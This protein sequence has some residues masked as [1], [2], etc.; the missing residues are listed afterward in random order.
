MAYNSTFDKLNPDVGAIFK[1]T[2]QAVQDNVTEMI[3]AYTTDAQ[4]LHHPKG[5]FNAIF[6]DFLNNQSVLK[7][8]VDTLDQNKLDRGGYVGTAQNLKSEVDDKLPKGTYAGDAGQLKTAID[9]KLAAGTY[10]GNAGQLKG[11]IDLKQNKNDS[12]LH[13]TSKTV[14]GS[15]NETLGIAQS[16]SANKQNKNDSALGTSNKTVVGAI[17]ELNSGKEPKFNKNSGFNKPI[18]SSYTLNNSGYVASAK[19]V[20][21]LYANRSATYSNDSNDILAT[22]KGVKYA[23]D[24]GTSAYNLANSKLGK[25]YCPYNVGDIY[26]TTNSNNPSTVWSGTSWQ[27]IQGKFLLGSSS[28]HPKG[29]TGGS[30]THKLTVNEMP[31][32]THTYKV[33]SSVQGDA[34]ASEYGGAIGRRGIHTYNTGAS[35]AN[36]A[37]NIMPPFL[38]VNMWKRTS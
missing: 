19:S 22:V 10:T 13:T 18:T 36:Q 17:N 23:Y 35:G 6:Q 33:G 5:D 38:S 15:I 20:Y 14:V 8:M 11:E 2:L 21:D 9:L 30:E 3:G 4:G 24:R 1:S 32:H 12:G 27:Q 29:T 16:N 31:A 37:F 28:S 7:G 34:Y 25:N 26:I